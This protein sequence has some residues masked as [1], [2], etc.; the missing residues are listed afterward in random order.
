[1]AVTD[2]GEPLAG[3]NILVVEDEYF[4]ADDLTR[5]LT[6]AGAEIIGPIND[7]EEALQIARKTRVD[8]GI[9]D[10][11]VRGTLIYAVAEELKRRAIPFVF[12]TGYDEAAIPDQFADVP[13][14]EKP[15]DPATLV[16]TL[17]QVIVPPKED[18]ALP[19][20]AAI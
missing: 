1:M 8:G 5:A 15:F 10:I 4:L 13:R 17:P 6:A 2:T 12:A 19:R 20:R 18:D 7:A 9:L 14:W 11:N 3:R 16:H